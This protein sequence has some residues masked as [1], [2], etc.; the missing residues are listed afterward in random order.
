[1]RISLYYPFAIALIAAMVW[2]GLKPGFANQEELARVRQSIAQSGYSITGEALGEAALGS[3]VDMELRGPP[4]L[5]RAVMTASGGPNEG[6]ASHGVLFALPPF[7]LPEL[8]GRPVEIAID[9]RR[10][11]EG[12]ATES[13][14]RVD[15]QGHG[16]SG[17]RPISV[18]EEFSVVGFTFDVPDTEDSDPI[19]VLVWPDASG[20]GLEIEVREVIVRPAD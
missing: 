14:L 6:A 19:V 17:W 15:V 10:A 12:G 8:A 7:A 4:S 3:R 11:R 20:E 13:L 9:A 16:S 18:G 1:M 5:R 2:M